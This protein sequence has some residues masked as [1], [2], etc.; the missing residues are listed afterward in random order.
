M[1]KTK[2]FWSAQPCTPKCY[3]PGIFRGAKPAHSKLFGVHRALLQKFGVFLKL[4][5]EGE[6]SLKSVEVH[7]NP[8][9]NKQHS[10]EADHGQ[11]RSGRG[12]KQSKSH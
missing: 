7:P 4:G 9:F 5:G 3:F 12:H 11:T 1:S 10:K 2:F 6:T 8:N